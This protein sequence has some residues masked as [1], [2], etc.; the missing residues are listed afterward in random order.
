MQTHARIC[1]E[2]RIIR[3]YDTVNTQYRE[4]WI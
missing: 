2:L 1:I 4:R 3:L